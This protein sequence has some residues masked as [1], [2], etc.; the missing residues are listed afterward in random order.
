MIRTAAAISLLTVISMAAVSQAGE[1]IL[2]ETE[3]GVYV[4]L[5]GEKA[6]EA[7]VEQPVV[8]PKLTDEQKNEA[9]RLQRQEK[10]LTKQKAK[11]LKRQQEPE[12]GEEE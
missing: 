2:R 7:K 9:L 12:E 1:M 10:R 11:K 3:A 4:E 8:V 5:T 6:P